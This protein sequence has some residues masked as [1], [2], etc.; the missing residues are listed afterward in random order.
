M[1]SPQTKSFKSGNLRRSQRLLL[2][3]HVVVSGKQ[4]SGASFAE[5]T[6]TQVVNAHGALVLLKQMVSV[7][8]RLRLRNV[9]TGDEISCSV[10]DIGELQERKSGIGIEFDQPSPRFWRISFPP[11]DWTPKSAEAKRYSGERRPAAK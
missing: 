6:V 11:D 8:D 1:D 5:E 10:V 2:T 3:V 9:K 7:G 4:A